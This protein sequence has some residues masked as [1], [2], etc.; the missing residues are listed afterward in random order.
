MNPTLPQTLQIAVLL[1]YFRAVFTLLFGA[2]DQIQVVF[3][4][5]DLLRVLLTAAMVAGAYGIANT[6]KWGY[7][8]ALVAAFA[9]LVARLLLGFGISFDLDVGAVS[10]LDYD[11]FGLL[12]EVALAVVLLHP[13]SREYQKSYFE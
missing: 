7:A 12:F 10:P 4:F 11:V 5:D 9:P 13:Q 6:R 8:L 3:P 2:D 1:L